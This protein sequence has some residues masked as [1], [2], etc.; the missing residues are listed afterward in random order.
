MERQFAGALNEELKNRECADS[1]DSQKQGR[2]NAMLLTEFLKE[3][4]KVLEQTTE[5]D[6][7]RRS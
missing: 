2:I 6:C 1:A 4:H 5:I 3:H 7:L